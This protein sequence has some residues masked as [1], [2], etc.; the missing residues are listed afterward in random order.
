MEERS[1]AIEVALDGDDN[2]IPELEAKLEELRAA[3]AERG[4]VPLNWRDNRRY[5]ARFCI[6][7]PEADTAVDEGVQTLREASASVGLPEAPVVD[8]EASTLA[9]VTRAHSDVEVPELIGVTELAELLGVGHHLVTLL[10]R[11]KGF[12]PPA[13]ELNA[14]PVWT[15]AAVDRF[16][17]RVR[18]DPGAT[19]SSTRPG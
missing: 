8:V 1:V 18:S 6:S 5:G 2:D 10:V 11:A 14:G 3:I 4:G 19:E 12:P 13:A 17:R 9:E 15:V 7:A 16:L